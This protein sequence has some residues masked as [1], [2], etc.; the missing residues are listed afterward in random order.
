MQPAEAKSTSHQCC[1][2]ITLHCFKHE[3]AVGDRL[4]C[5]ALLPVPQQEQL[6]AKPEVC[7]DTAAHHSV[8]VS[9]AANPDL[10]DAASAP[11]ATPAAATDQPSIDDLPPDV[12]RLLP[13]ELLEQGPAALLEQLQQYVQLKQQLVGHK[14]ATIQPGQQESH[15][16]TT[17]VQ[18]VHSDPLHALAAACEE[19][20]GLLKYKQ[21]CE[22]SGSDGSGTSCTDPLEV[23]PEHLNHRTVGR[24]QG[25]LSNDLPWSEQAAAVAESEGEQ[26]QL[27]SQHDM[28]MYIKKQLQNQS[29]SKERSHM[30]R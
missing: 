16:R 17:R 20:D 1:T 29:N 13:K 27:P 30:A 3:L 19:Q 5:S 9:A 26:Q 7:S 23:S 8:S 22:R 18:V 28:A 25:E 12:L 15:R 4:L 24:R 10:N 11:L 21:H 2:C 14:H 6:T